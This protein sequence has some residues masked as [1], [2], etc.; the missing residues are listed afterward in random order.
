MN[1]FSVDVLYPVWESPAIR[2]VIADHPFLRDP[3]HYGEGIF[4]EDWRTKKTVLAY[5]DSMNVIELSWEK[6]FKHT[7]NKFRSNCALIRWDENDPLADIFCLQFGR[8]PSQQNFSYNFE[9]AFINGLRAREVTIA[10]GAQI[11][12]TLIQRVTP[13]DLTSSELIRF[14]GGWRSDD[15]IYIGNEKSFEDLVNFWNLRAAGS[16]ILFL[17]RDH[18]PRQRAL[19]EAHL[20]KL[21]NQRASNPNLEDWITVYF[22]P[23]LDSQVRD[24]L[25]GLETKKRQI[26]HPVQD[27]VWNGLNIK[28]P[29]YLFSWDSSLANVEESFGKPVVTVGLPPKKFLTNTRQ[30]NI[31][32]QNLV[33][34]IDSYSEFDFPEH[35]LKPPPIRALNEFYSRQIAVDPW[36][37]RVDRDGI[38]LIKD[39][40]DNCAR[41]YPLSHQALIERIFDLAGITAEMSK[42]GLLASQIIKSMREY[43]PLEACRVFKLRGVR[44]LLNSLTSKDVIG[45]NDALR[46]IGKESFNKFKKLHIEPRKTLDLGP[47][48]AL[49]FLLKKKILVPHLRILERLLPRYKTFKCVKCG[50]ESQISVSAFEH[51]W[52]CPY[53][54]HE[55]YLPPLIGSE[56]KQRDM[57]HFKKA[58]LFSR[59]N[60]QEGSIPV[61]LTLLVFLRVLDSG[62]FIFSPSL[63]LK[64][65]DNSCETDLCVL[66]YHHGDA[67]EIGVGECKAEKG[68]ITSQDVLHLKAMREKLGAVGLKCYLVFAKTADE[69]YEDER[70]LFQQLKLEGVP[71]ILFTNREIEPY[72]PYWER[73]N[74]GIPV[75]NPFT[76]AEL[77]RNSW[78]IYLRDASPT[79][80]PPNQ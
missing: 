42:P 55:L 23:S 24:I 47:T 29:T 53:C 80:H 74:E 6:E 76:L 5:L 43:S 64:S 60:N 78:H 12:K 69:F 1:L 62:K 79:G 72:N 57:W 52:R 2:K 51:N 30:R 71:F 19:I 48:D 46:I 26:E 3:R 44:K 56:F 50:L 33:V 22:S 58:G 31:D 20:K 73:E 14:G 25:T 9:K 21:D 75:Q 18:L 59:D 4:Y 66:Q 15:G 36:E 8:Y 63:N 35:T 41:L 54:G 65:S 7:N 68:S 61:I 11:D 37:L 38:A 17:A 28:P 49:T 27:V 77:A 32:L 13:I 67:I 16:H 40:R 45:W 70:M 34:I 39:T 10:A